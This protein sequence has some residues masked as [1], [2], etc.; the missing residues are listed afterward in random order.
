MKVIHAPNVGCALYEG[1]RY[2]KEYGMDEPSRNGPVKVAPN[3]VVTL[4]NNPCQRVLTDPVRD[5]N[6]FFH[7]M[8][9]LW[10]IAGRNDVAWISRFSSGI[11][12]Y[13]DDGVIFHGAYGH[14][15]RH[16]FG[17][18]QIEVICN[19]LRANPQCRRQILQMWDPIADLGMEGKDFPCNQS[20]HFQVKH[21]R[22]EMT[23]FNRSNDVVF[24]AYG[25][26][27][28]HFSMLL[29][30]MAAKVGVPVGRYWQVSD[31]YHVYDNVMTKKKL[32]GLA[33][34]APD[35]YHTKTYPDPYEWKEIEPYPM[36]KDPEK[37]D[38]DLHMFMENGAECYGYNEPFFRRVAVPLLRAWNTYKDG[39]KRAAIR[40][41]DAC[42]A[43]DWKK[44]CTEWLTRR[45]TPSVT[46]GNQETS[47]EPTTSPTGEATP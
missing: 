3:P 4:Y 25:A 28:V 9:S 30:Y 39:D 19:A 12:Q 43:T 33:D 41:L 15:W 2:L 37:W 45:L 32:W 24:G 16:Y 20:A 42:S 22:L 31:N 5:A 18:D 14:R 21:G 23:V 17:S 34:K 36:V 40:E 26:N 27:A 13:S 11:A 35:G 44:A 47:N 46:S 10:M 6:P 29:E 8:E 7:F 1:I 38:R